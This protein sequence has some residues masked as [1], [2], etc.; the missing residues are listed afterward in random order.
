MFGKGA[1]M[2][3]SRIEILVVDDDPALRQLLTLV[4]LKSGYAV[5]SAPDGFSALAAIRTGSG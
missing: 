1:Y 2:S 3:K 5:R 4:L